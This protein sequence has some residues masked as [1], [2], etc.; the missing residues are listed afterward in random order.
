[1]RIAR[2][3]HLF[4]KLLSTHS[5]QLA[6]S[7]KGYICHAFLSPVVSTRGGACDDSTIQALGPSGC[8]EDELGSRSVKPS[9]SV[10]GQPVDVSTQG[11]PLLSPVPTASACPPPPNTHPEANN[12]SNSAPSC[13][14]W[15][16]IAITSELYV[17][18]PRHHRRCH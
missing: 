16:R 18:P 8:P 5:R 10:P 17:F 11:G 2:W 7:S 3:F 4:L 9:A 12:I 15:P 1:M 14:D 13:W 6:W